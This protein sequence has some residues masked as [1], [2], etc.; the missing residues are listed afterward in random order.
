MVKIFCLILLSLFSFVFSKS[1]E[2]SLKDQKIISCMS[3]SH[4]NNLEFS[5]KLA[6]N[7]ESTKHN[8]KNEVYD[9]LV[10]G[11][12][13]N[14]VKGISVK[15]IEFIEVNFLDPQ[16]LR[17]HKMMDLVKYRVFPILLLQLYLKHY[18]III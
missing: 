5:G 2:F 18:I 11:S 8:N 16:A 14:C 3:L 7:I 13:L 1:E 9:K 4:A 6:S 15:E 17:N 10:Y 12:I